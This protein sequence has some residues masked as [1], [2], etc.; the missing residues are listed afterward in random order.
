[1]TMDTA[2]EPTSPRP[3][4]RPTAAW[5]I[6]TLLGLLVV[7]NGLSLGL[8]VHRGAAENP[9]RLALS[10]AAW[11]GVWSRARLVW[12][13]GRLLISFYAALAT[14]ALILAL[15]DL[16]NDWGHLALMSAA[17]L[18]LDVLALAFWRPSLKPYFGMLC[19]HCG[20]TG[21]AAGSLFRQ[22]RCR[23]CGLVW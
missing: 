5:V 16:R 8:A 1:M 6:L 4:P 17:V 23:E 9:V 2:F 18:P 13:W 10:V 22:A 12:Q 20:A 3:S 11:A 21:R 15:A 7:I 19:P 14:A